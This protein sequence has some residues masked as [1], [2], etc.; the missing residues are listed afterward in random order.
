[1]LRVGAGAAPSKMR[2]IQGIQIN[3]LAGFQPDGAGVRFRA[4]DGFKV[5]DDIPVAIHIQQVHSKVRAN[6]LPAPWP[7]CDV[8]VRRSESPVIPDQADRCAAHAGVL[9]LYADSI[10]DLDEGVSGRNGQKALGPEKSIGFGRRD[11]KA[12]RH[13]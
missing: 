2:K 6:G 13:F 1:M 3:G 4:C 12:V 11:G 5:Q 8:V 10:G 7:K 9:D